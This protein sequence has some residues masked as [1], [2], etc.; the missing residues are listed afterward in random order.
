MT[1]NN[2]IHNLN[3]IMIFVYNFR[4][5]ERDRL[6]FPIDIGHF[7]WNKFTPHYTL[8]IR[9]YIAKESLE[10]MD[11]AKRK[12]FQLKIAHYVVLVVYYSLLA[13]FYYYLLKLFGVTSYFQNLFN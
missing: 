5:D 11:R 12:H 9:K 8:G 6:Y 7:N 1:G 2:T 4:M 13:T 3:K 10:N